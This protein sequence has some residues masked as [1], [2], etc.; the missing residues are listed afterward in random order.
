MCGRDL[1]A[2]SKASAA[3]KKGGVAFVGYGKVAVSGATFHFDK[4][5]TY[6][7]P[8]RPCGAVFLGSMVLV[9]F[10]PGEQTAHGRGVGAGQQ[11]EP[12][13]CKELFDAAP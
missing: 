5:Y 6:L 13:R 8:P 1:Y 9:P 3:V 10:W 2:D 12:G 7:L 11:E 4:L